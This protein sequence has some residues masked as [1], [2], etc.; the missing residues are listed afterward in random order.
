MHAAEVE[1]QAVAR[2]AKVDAAHAEAEA[3][4]RYSRGELLG[5]TPGKDS[6]AGRQVVDRMRAEGKIRG[7]PPNEEVFHAPSQQWYPLAE[8]E[9]GH[10]TDAVTWWKKEGMYYGEKSDIVRDWMLDPNNY[11]LEPGGINASRG[12][13]LTDRYV[14]PHPDPITPDELA[15]KV[16]D[17]TPKPDY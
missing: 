12:A 2:E 3:E 14:P 15:G 6:P 7:A 10:T 1:A 5:K 4:R 17:R 8:C 9:M 11:E 13:K 16:K